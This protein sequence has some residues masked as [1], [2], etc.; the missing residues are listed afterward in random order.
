MCCWTRHATPK[1]FTH[2]ILSGIT[3]RQFAN[4][5]DH[6]ATGLFAFG[7]PSSYGDWDA[8][9]DLAKQPSGEPLHRFAGQTNTVMMASDG[10]GGDPRPLTV[11]EWEALSVVEFYLQGRIIKRGNGVRSDGV[12]FCGIV[13]R[14]QDGALLDA[15]ATGVAWRSDTGG[16]WSGVS[17]L[18]KLADGSP[19]IDVDSLV[20]LPQVRWVDPASVEPPE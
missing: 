10:I 13:V 6:T 15:L 17:S 16:P 18:Y 20:E 1:A 19:R 2:L 11:A 7:H 4:H 8:L 12:P 5:I 9:T 3:G 14:D